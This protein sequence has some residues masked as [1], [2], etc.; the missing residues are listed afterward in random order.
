MS[1]SLLKA[2]DLGKFTYT[3]KNIKP[4]IV[5]KDG[6]KTLT[7][8]T[9]YTLFYKDNKNI[10]KATVTA[11]LKGDY[12]GTITKQFSIVPSKPTL[13]AVRSGDNIKL[14]W[15]ASKGCGKYQIQYSTD[16]GKTYKTLA[17]AS[18]SK[19][20]YTAKL[21]NGNYRFRIRGYKNVDKTTYYGNWSKV[22]K[23][24]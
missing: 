13:K 10:G 1:P 3:G 16:G 5:I 6:D 18:S 12:T 23:V 19:T 15:T 21:K 9:D 20:S 17:K 7:R 8:G 4:D 11:A 2:D 24:K 14:T 22:V